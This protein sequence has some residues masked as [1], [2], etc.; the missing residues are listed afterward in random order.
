M[1]PRTLST[2]DLKTLTNRQLN[3]MYHMAQLN[4][5]YDALHVSVESALSWLDFVLVCRHIVTERYR[6]KGR[7]DK[8]HAAF[9]DRLVDEQSNLAHFLYYRNCR[10]F[11]FE[12][13]RLVQNAINAGINVPEHFWPPRMFMQ[14]VTTN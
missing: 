14:P 10:P 6:I 1:D 4:V 8:G 3:N 11:H 12:C 9:F 13:W 2:N 7:A 5:V